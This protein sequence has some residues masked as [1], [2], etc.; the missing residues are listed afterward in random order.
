MTHQFPG[1]SA[2]A[3][4]SPVLALDIGGTKIAAGLVDAN[5]QLLHSNRQPT[6]RSAEP[7][8]VWAAAERTI[9]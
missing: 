2:P 1:R 9:A 3:R 4:R 8:E 7:D 5:G 6:P